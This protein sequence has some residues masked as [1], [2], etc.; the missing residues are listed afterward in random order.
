M[1]ANASVVFSP[2]GIGTTENSW[3]Q[4]Y[5]S[6]GEYSDPNYSSAT[7]KAL[8]SDV[9]YALDVYPIASEFTGIDPS[10]SV[11]RATY[12][13]EDM[14]FIDKG[15]AINANLTNGMSA[16]SVGGISYTSNFSKFFK[17]EFV[18]MY[19][20]LGVTARFS[21]EEKAWAQAKGLYTETTVG[22]VGG[23]QN[24]DRKIIKFWGLKVTA[25]YS[26]I[27]RNFEF[28]VGL[29]SVKE[30]L[31]N[32]QPE[33]T[34]PAKT[35]VESRV[36]V[37]V[38]NAAPEILDE[39]FNAYLG[40]YESGK[41]A[42]LKGDDNVFI[43]YLPKNMSV[44]VTPYDFVKD[45]DVYA[46]SP[47]GG[48]DQK[49]GSNPKK[50]VNG[51]YV[52]NPAYRD[53]AIATNGVSKLTT[54]AG[55]AINSPTSTLDNVLND[56]LSFNAL[57]KVTNAEYT[58]YK[59]ADASF[60]VTP[61]V[62][63]S[64]ER[65]DEL[66]ITG[67]KKSSTRYTTYELQIADSAADT[68]S[69]VTVKLLVYVLN[70]APV[71]KQTVAPN[72]N[73]FTLQAASQYPTN[74]FADTGENP[75]AAPNNDT[76]FQRQTAYNQREYLV[77]ELVT[78]IDAEDI[79]NLTFDSTSIQVGTLKSFTLNPTAAD[80]IPFA[81]GAT[82]NPFVSASLQSGTGMRSTSGATVLLLIGKSSTQ[83]LANGVW[84]KF[85]ASDG[86][87]SSEFYIQVEVVNSEASMNTGAFA[88]Q[89]ADAA[90]PTELP[91]GYYLNI[92]TDAADGNATS[93]RYLTR[94][95]CSKPL[96]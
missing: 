78:D 17:V 93:A 96:R 91:A 41:P 80:F 16:Y 39:D 92:Q 84:V 51:E 94:R 4:I 76:T 64:S 49:T 38:S 63:V 42:W 81:D 50:W 73:Y 18:E 86:T 69:V 31:R 14:L 74:S 23:T 7:F 40:D 2:M 83:G 3:G 1:S 11:W 28:A 82:E 62:T 13:F 9:D 29:Q 52:D 26:T 70:T 21:P 48:T 53:A 32:L 65:F 95:C 20:P 66:T 35:T 34:L 77:R 22:A 33:Y 5:T 55:T 12:A 19:L 72:T 46:F 60:A 75:G 68:N 59:D 47:L 89:A 45:A 27:G 54:A 37:G 10:D 67:A 58:N 15:A 25:L 71:L 57:P 36:L 24:T 85:T 87:Y 30:G 44:K 43:Y 6:A 90:N 79:E 8:A 88:E 61:G 56:R